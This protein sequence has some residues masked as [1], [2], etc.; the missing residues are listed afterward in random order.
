[1]SVDRE[2]AIAPAADSDK[3]QASPAADLPQRIPN[4]LLNGLI[5]SL[6]AATITAA[7]L[8]FVNAWIV[9][10][11]SRHQ[12][13]IDRMQEAMSE[14][15]RLA[16]LLYGSTWNV[17]HEVQRPNDRTN[18]PLEDLQN[19]MAAS[20]GLGIRLSVVFNERVAEEWGVISAE[21]IVN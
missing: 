13:Q 5:G 10:T 14:A 21:A 20:N 8:V 7:V 16:S 11:V 3:P 4:P 6:L 18:K 1:M 9:P 19:V 15:S 17:W 2:T 12:K